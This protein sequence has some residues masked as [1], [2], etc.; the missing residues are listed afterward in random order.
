VRVLLTIDEGSYEGG[1][2][3]VDHPIAWCDTID[4]GRT[5]YTAGGHTPESYAEPL[6]RQHVLGGL[7]WSA[8]FEQ[9]PRCAGDLDCS[10]GVDLADLAALLANYGGSEAGY[11]GGD[12]DQDGDVDLADLS[13]LLAMFGTS[14][15]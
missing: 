9:V 5:L 13:G 7:F 8:G 6:F 11:R 12:V 14:C 15:A 4:N 3:G 10:G 2:M 1:T